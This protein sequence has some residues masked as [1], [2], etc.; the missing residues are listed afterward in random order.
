[1]IKNVWA[2][3]KAIILRTKSMKHK[4]VR[5]LS[6]IID[7]NNVIMLTIMT[8]NNINMLYFIKHFNVNYMYKKIPSNIDGI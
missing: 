5:S 1:M 2:N 3:I 6:H 8:H 7:L 4:Y